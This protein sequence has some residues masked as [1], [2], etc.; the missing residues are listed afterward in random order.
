MSIL[1]TY[2]LILL[3]GLAVGCQNRQSPPHTPPGPVD[4]ADT[5]AQQVQPDTDQPEEMPSD[6]S[7]DAMTELASASANEPKALPGQ[8]QPCPHGYCAKGLT[9]M[10]YYG[11]AGPLGPKFSSC[12]IPCMGKTLDCPKGQQCVTIADGPGQVCRPL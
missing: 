2:V 5:S 1:R 8:G 3:A 12:E 4:S 10:T 6:S 7:A 11:I 9:C